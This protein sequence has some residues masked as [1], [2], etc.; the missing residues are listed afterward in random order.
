MLTI[1]VLIDGDSLFICSFV[2]G[3]TLVKHSLIY[4]LVKNS[5]QFFA[6][7]AASFFFSS[8]SGFVYH[9]AEIQ[10]PIQHGCDVQHERVQVLEL[11]G[12]SALSRSSPSPDVTHLAS[13]SAPPGILLCADALELEPHH[14]SSLEI[15]IS[16]ALLTLIF[17]PRTLFRAPISA[18][19]MLY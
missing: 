10:Y 6:R 8:H 5:G 9:Y 3:Q 18:E 12:S 17:H 1:D 7:P 13:K 16:I 14:W 11:L 19:D 15:S 4:L 2:D